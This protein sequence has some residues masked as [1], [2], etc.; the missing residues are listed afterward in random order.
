MPLHAE[1]VYTMA[2]FRDFIAKDG[3]V[4]DRNLGIEKSKIVSSGNLGIFFLRIN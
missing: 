4:E 2:I 1:T 3:M